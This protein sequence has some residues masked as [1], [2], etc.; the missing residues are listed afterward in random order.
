MQYKVFDT[1]D[2]DNNTECIAVFPLQPWLRER[3][4]MLRYTCIACLVPLRV[5]VWE[6]LA[7][8]AGVPKSAVF[9]ISQPLPFGLN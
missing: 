3:A 8:I 4:A 5:S 1:V 6:L 9:S 2:I 7:A